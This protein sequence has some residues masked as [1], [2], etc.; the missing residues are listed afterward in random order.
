MFRV[1]IS[2]GLESIYL[3]MGEL[4]LLLLAWIIAFVVGFAHIALRSIS[5][6]ASSTTRAQWWGPKRLAFYYFLYLRFIVPATV[7]TPCDGYPSKPQYNEKIEKSRFFY[8]HMYLNPDKTELWY[9]TNKKL[10]P[11]Y[12]GSVHNT[13]ICTTWQF[14]F[15]EAFVPANWKHIQ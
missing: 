8:A 1:S 3:Y 12:W 14:C 10:G 15:F 11:L 13:S 6:M 2:F 4:L 7:E 5:A 9:N